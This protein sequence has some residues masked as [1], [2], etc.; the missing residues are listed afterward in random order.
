ML[1]RPAG[2]DFLVLLRASSTRGLQLTATDSPSSTLQISLG[3][4]NSLEYMGDHNP[5]LAEEIVLWSRQ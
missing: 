3:T 2:F 5:C 1:V 4:K